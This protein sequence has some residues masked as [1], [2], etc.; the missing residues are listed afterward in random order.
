MGIADGGL[1][2]IFTW[3]SDYD[4]ESLGGASGYPSYLHI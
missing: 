3:W 1:K 2:D 4:L